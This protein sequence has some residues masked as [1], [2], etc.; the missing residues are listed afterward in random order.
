MLTRRHHGARASNPGATKLRLHLGS[1]ELGVSEA[2]YHAWR[3]RPASAHAVADAALLKQVRTVH[4]SSRETYGAP[5]VHAG[6]RSE[7][8]WRTRRHGMDASASRGS[9]ARPAS[10]APAAG[11]AGLSQRG[12]TRTPDPRRTWWTATSPPP[13]QTSAGEALLR[14]EIADITFIPSAAG[15]LYLAVVLDAWSRKPGAERPSEVVGSGEDRRA[16]APRP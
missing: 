7:G 12:R 9:C 15:F 4:A 10:S 1:P 5:R 16:V 8:A 2:G 3:H 13:A 14:P 11:G 6:L